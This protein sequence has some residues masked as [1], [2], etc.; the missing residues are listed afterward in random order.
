MI[1]AAKHI[2][3]LIALFTLSVLA[4]AEGNA[5]FERVNVKVSLIEPAE[6]RSF[7]PIVF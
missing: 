6:V 7:P 5:V 3:M 4:A 2:V 1:G